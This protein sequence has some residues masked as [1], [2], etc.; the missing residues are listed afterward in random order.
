MQLTKYICDLS[1]K[2]GV[3]VRI[4][5]IQPEDAPMEKD[6][7]E[8]LGP[9]SDFSRFFGYFKEPSSEDLRSLC[10]IDY[11]T[12]MALVA[13]VSGAKESELEMII[14]VA[15][16]IET[17]KNRAEFAIVVADEYQHLGLGTKLTEMLLDFSKNRGYDSVYAAIL[18]ENWIMIQ[19][20]TSKFKFKIKYSDDRLVIAELSL[21]NTGDTSDMSTALNRK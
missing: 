18:P 1:L 2:G 7:I 5:P 13:L 17:T 14:G 8:R 3:H 20:I 21:A 9:Q 11:E 6:F 16:L 19:M 4:R 10:N 12:Q 15:R